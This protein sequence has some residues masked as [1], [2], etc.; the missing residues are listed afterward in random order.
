MFYFYRLPGYMKVLASRVRYACA[1]VSFYSFFSRKCIV[2]D[3][4]SLSPRCL[5]LM[6]SL[7][8]STSSLPTVFYFSFHC[9]LSSMFSDSFLIIGYFSPH[10]L[11]L[12]LPLLSSITSTAFPIVH[13]GV[14]VPGMPSSMTPT[15]HI[16]LLQSLF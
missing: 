9:L 5:L 2:T 3:S 12:F 8:S 13:Y 11:L 15:L 4:V 6:L 10:S 14:A 7:L 16:P 1:T